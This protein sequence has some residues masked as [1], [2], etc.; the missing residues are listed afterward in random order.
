MGPL[1]PAAGCQPGM[2]GGM[3]C[4]GGCPG[5][6]WPGWWGGMPIIGPIMA[7]FMGLGP[8]PDMG[9]GPGPGKGLGPG[10]GIIPAGPW[11][12]MPCRGDIMG[13]WMP[14]CCCLTLYSSMSSACSFCCLRICVGGRWETRG[15]EEERGVE[16]GVGGGSGEW[17]GEDKRR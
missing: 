13:C 14:C 11:G 10:P 2:L 7:G 1:G 4:C 6:G 5:L 17:G 15:G 12:G 9:L 3:G 16:W 8:G